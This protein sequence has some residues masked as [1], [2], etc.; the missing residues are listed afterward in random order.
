MC[1]LLRTESLGRLALGKAANSLLHL[2]APYQEFKICWELLFLWEYLQRRPSIFKIPSNNYNIKC[3]VLLWYYSERSS[4][5]MN[6]AESIPVFLLCHNFSLFCLSSLPLYPAPTPISSPSP[7][8]PSSFCP[9]IFN[10]SSTQVSHCPTS[11]SVLHRLLRVI[12]KEDQGSGIRVHR[13]KQTNKQTILGM[14]D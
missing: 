6:L 5:R 3:S 14:Q 2:R 13:K 8:P 9:Q 12:M 10:T 7:L 4:E 11:Q 1:S